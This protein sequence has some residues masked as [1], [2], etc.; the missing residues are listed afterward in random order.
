MLVKLFLIRQ[1]A[2]D[3][4]LILQNKTE[5]KKAAETKH[6]NERHSESGTK[7]LCCSL[8]ALEGMCADGCLPVCATRGF[9]VG[10]APWAARAAGGA[11]ERGVET[12][13]L[14]VWESAD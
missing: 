9:R 6:E 3:P 11:A 14:E 4:F 2:F 13:G 12:H 10:L 7:P 1:W 5:Q 8:A